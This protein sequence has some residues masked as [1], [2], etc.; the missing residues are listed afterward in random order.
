MVIIYT[1]N[2]CYKCRDGDF[3]RVRRMCYRDTLHFFLPLHPSRLNNTFDF[4]LKIVKNK[5][6]FGQNTQY[7]W[8][9]V[10]RVDKYTRLGET[11]IH[12]VP[13]WLG[14]RWATFTNIYTFK[15][16]TYT[17]VLRLETKKQTIYRSIWLL[18]IPRE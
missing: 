5:H 6:L 15:F 11:R 16:N 17:N 8:F 14:F 10:G 9:P 4:P 18:L 12:L 1:R 2:L 7:V 3:V 13:G